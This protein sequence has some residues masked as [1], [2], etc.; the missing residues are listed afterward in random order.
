M[1]EELEELLDEHHF[2]TFVVTT[3]DG[4]SIAI[5][6]P[7]KTL[8]GNRVLIVMDEA[9]RFYHIPFTAISH[10]SEPPEASSEEASNVN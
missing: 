3:T 2:S 7:R 4:F 6:N 5:N 10:I 8:I 9:G 1:K